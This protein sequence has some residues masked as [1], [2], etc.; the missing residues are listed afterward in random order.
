M[1][2][3]PQRACGDKRLYSAVPPPRCFIAAAVDLA[4]MRAAYR[5]RERI[6]HLATERMGLRKTQL[7]RIRPDADRK[8]GRVV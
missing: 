1:G 2:C 7:M 8:S 5:H 6:A 4:V 3:K